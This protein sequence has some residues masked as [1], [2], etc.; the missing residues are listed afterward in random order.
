MARGSSKLVSFGITSIV[1]VL[2]IISGPAQA[3][4]LS[5]NIQNPKVILGETIKLNL[6]SE[7]EQDENINVQKFTLEI[8][9]PKNITCEFDTNAEDL[10][11]CEGITIIKTSEDNDSNYGYD[12]GY[13]Y[14]YSYDYG[15]GNSAQILGY[16]ININTQNYTPG[17][18]K[19]KI[20]A[21]SKDDEFETESKFIIFTNDKSIQGC[22]FRGEKGILQVDGFATSANRL[23]VNIALEKAVKSEGYLYSQ[24]GKHRFSYKF[25][26][27][28]VISNSPEEAV[29]LVSGVYKNDGYAKTDETATITLD[30]INKKI[31]IYGESI[32][33][34]N[35]NAKF[36][37]NC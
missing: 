17:Q 6:S 2:L 19:A 37:K 9:G 14:G 29:L 16:E 26:T 28:G 22:S 23:N 21:I 4:L 11:G 15:Y 27:E 12:Y 7:S 32:N 30:K 1:L 20:K 13:S 8:S 10:T 18:Y 31:F 5:L 36:I 34:Q 33:L 35:M 24:L 25:K 3:F